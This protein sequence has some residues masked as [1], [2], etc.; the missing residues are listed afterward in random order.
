MTLWS[1]DFAEIER[2]AARRRLG[3]AVARS[4]P[5][6]PR[7][8]ARRRVRGDRARRRTRCTWS[9]TTITRRDR[10]V[11]FID[12]VDVDGRG[13]AEPVRRVGLLGTGYTMTS[14]MYPEPA[15]AASAS[16]SSCP[17]AAEQ[18]RGARGHLRRAR[19]T[20]SSPSE[21]RAGLPRA[22]IEQARRR[23][24]PGGRPGLH[25]AGTAAR[26]TATRPCRCSTPPPLHCARR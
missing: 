25:R 12:L 9:P 1:V 10:R 8:A 7:R 14:D 17:E 15:R 26:A 23:G 13:R 19:R 6:R 2:A 21:S 3:R 4:W 18:R 5:T 16:T 20:A 24:R 11:P 22:S